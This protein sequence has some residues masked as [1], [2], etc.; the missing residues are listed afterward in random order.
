MI[1]EWWAASNDTEA[2]AAVTKTT[3]RKQSIG[4][5]MALY[6]TLGVETPKREGHE[7]RRV[8]LTT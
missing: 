4:E 6:G 7:G 2:L 3:R 1:F 8:E 5:R